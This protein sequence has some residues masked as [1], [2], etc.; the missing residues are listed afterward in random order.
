MSSDDESTHVG[1]R[2]VQKFSQEVLSE[3]NELLDALEH[4]HRND[5]ALHLYS[6]FLLKSVLKAANRKKYGLETNTFIKT[7]IKDNWTSWPNPSTVIDPKIDTIFEDVNGSR[8]TNPDA[9]IPGNISPDELQHGAKMVHGE[10]NAVWQQSLTK[11][12]SENG[13]VLDIDK[14]EIPQGITMAVL[15]KMDHFFKGIHTNIASMNKLV[16]TQT[17]GTSQLKVTEHQPNE[18]PLDMNRKIKLDYH[19]V[20]MR[21]CQMG[22]E[23][24]DVYMKGLELFSDIPSKYRNQEFKLPQEEI[25]KY[26]S[27][28]RETNQEKPKTANKKAGYI[29]A[30]TLLHRNTLSFE[31]RLKL[32]S[33][34]NKHQD[35]SLD[36]KTYLHLEN[37]VNARLIDR[38]QDINLSLNDCLVPI[39]RTKSRYARKKLR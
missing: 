21:G 7:Q 38:D 9:T 32:R 37:F 1:D 4:T 29:M 35:R 31:N 27:K 14:M 18:K 11:M 16:V 2:P 12:A 34:L 5:L 20:I 22:E 25:T 39:R 30:E 36:E 26:T 10:L 13:V 6:T 33:I 28:K 19:D 3:A 17:S 23:M 24:Y 8:P 15:S